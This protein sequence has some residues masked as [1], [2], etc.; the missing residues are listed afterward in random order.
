[1]MVVTQT[2][3]LGNKTRVGA[4]GAQGRVCEFVLLVGICDVGPTN[5]GS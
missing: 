5:K 4:Q 3:G 1:M 2:V